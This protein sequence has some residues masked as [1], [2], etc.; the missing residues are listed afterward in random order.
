MVL[1]SRSALQL[2]GS[3]TRE[4]P[5]KGRPLLQARLLALSGMSL[6]GLPNLP[7][8]AWIQRSGPPAVWQVTSY[9]S[10]GGGRW[11]AN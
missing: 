2:P 11:A 8:R 7:I 10:D 1:S 5:M 6:L 9:T 4:G 3:Q